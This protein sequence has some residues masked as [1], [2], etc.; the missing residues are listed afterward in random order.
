MK[1][2][3]ILN[4]LLIAASA[5]ADSGL[6]PL[7]QTYFCQGPQPATIVLEKAVPFFGP[8]PFS[9]NRMTIYSFRDQVPFSLKLL[10]S[11]AFTQTG[12][13][14]CINQSQT[15]YD[16][17]TRAFA[18]DVAIHLENSRVPRCA[19]FEKNELKLKLDFQPFVAE[20]LKDLEGEF[21]C[22]ATGVDYW[23][24]PNL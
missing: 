8:E 20:Y 13:E 16:I 9:L 10:L 19:G 17:S 23:F 15:T 12:S 14:G 24:N 1:T 5:G 7:S 11:G 21:T 2:L 18:G 4:T 3:L 22:H 6:E